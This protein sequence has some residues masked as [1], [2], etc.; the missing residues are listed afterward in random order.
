MNYKAKGEGRDSSEAAAVIQ[1]NDRGRGELPN[2]DDGKM[3][4]CY[5]MFC[6]F[7]IF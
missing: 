2:S 3:N 6:T 5:I 7:C 4:T 1:E